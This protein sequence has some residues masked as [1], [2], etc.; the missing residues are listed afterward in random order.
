MTNIMEYKS[1]PHEAF[2]V[3]L[4]MVSIAVI[5]GCKKK[6]EQEQ[7]DVIANKIPDL[8][9]QVTHVINMKEK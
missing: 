8:L 1:H 7:E 3:I 9:D 5:W 2:M 6:E 4:L